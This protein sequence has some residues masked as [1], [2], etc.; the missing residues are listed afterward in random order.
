LCFFNV[1]LLAWNVPFSPIIYEAIQDISITLFLIIT[2]FM[3]IGMIAINMILMYFSINEI[4]S[5]GAL[6]QRILTL[7]KNKKEFSKA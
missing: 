1:E 4:E 6:Q 3:M 5:A 7:K 2:L